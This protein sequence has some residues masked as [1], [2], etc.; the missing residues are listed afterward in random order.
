MAEDSKEE[1]LEGYVV[2]YNVR[3][4]ASVL[5]MEVYAR[6]KA[7]AME[8]AKMYHNSTGTKEITIFNVKKI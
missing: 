5:R 7:E 6:S 8:K 3:G 1:G 4:I 2:Y